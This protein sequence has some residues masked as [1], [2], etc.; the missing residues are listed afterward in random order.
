MFG[1]KKQIKIN[2]LFNHGFKIVRT[3]PW[4]S[5]EFPK[6]VK[7]KLPFKIVR[8]SPWGSTEFPKVVKTK[9][10]FMKVINHDYYVD[11]T[12]LKPKEQVK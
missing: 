12:E 5:T 8:T 7:T 2:L 6:V 11:F 4:G 1:R 3:S 9:L 10:P